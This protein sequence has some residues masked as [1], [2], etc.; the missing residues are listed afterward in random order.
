MSILREPSA[1]IRALSDG[2]VVADGAM[3]TLL[4]ELEWTTPSTAVIREPDKVKLVH[5]EYIRAGARLI[6][7]NTFNSNEWDLKLNKIT[8]KGAVRLVNS[9]AVQLARKV[10]EEFQVTVPIFVGGD[11]GP[12]SQDDGEDNDWYIESRSHIYRDQITALVE[13]RVDVLVFETMPSVREAS[14]A[15]GA[16]KDFDIPKVL[17]IDS[18]ALPPG[19]QALMKSFVNLVDFV[20]IFGFN[21]GAG[22]EEGLQLI[23][24]AKN[25][26]QLDRR[27]NSDERRLFLA[28]KPNAGDPDL[29]GP[30]SKYPV[31]PEYFGDFAVR[32]A[33]CGISLIGGCCGTKQAHI[34]SAS[35]AITGWQR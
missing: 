25:F 18:N 32:A 2:V 10:I 35:K 33:E 30:T 21:C 29:G 20:D 9:K 12:V 26:E 19:D 8:K 22:P 23:Q 16:A 17:M 4:S 6:L 14:I 31:T 28:V 27:L 24:E 7:T 34:E 11:I 5:R 1:F 15:L 3:G 13:A